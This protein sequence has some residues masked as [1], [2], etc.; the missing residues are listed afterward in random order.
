MPASPF[1]ALLPCLRDLV[2]RQDS[3][4]ADR[5]LLKRFVAERDEAASCRGWELSLIKDRLERGRERLRSRLARRGVLLGTALTS[6]WLLESGAKAALVPYTTARAA[7]L[8]AI[9]QATLADLLPVPVAALSRGGTTTML[10]CRL[11]ILA[12]CLVLALGAAVGLT[13]PVEEPTGKPA[14]ANAA[15]WEPERLPLT[16]HKGAVRAVAFAPDGKSVAT[17]GADKTIRIWEVATGAQKHKMAHAWDER[18]GMTD[19]LDRTAVSVGVAYSPDGK[20]LATH[21]TGKYGWLVFWDA[22]N[23]RGDWSQ[24]RNQ[25]RLRDEGGAVAYSADGKM[26]VAGFGGGITVVIENRTLAK[27]VYSVKG[28]NGRA[29]VAISP[30]SKLLAV[31][32]GG[33]IQL[34]DLPTG[35]VLRNPLGLRASDAVTSMAFLRGGTKVV[36]ADGGKGI[37]V[38]DTTTGNEERAFE[39]SDEVTTLASSADGKRLAT[40]GVGG[41]VVLWD[42]FGKEQRRFF[43]GGAVNAVAFNPDGTR[44]ATAGEGGVEL[45]DLKREARPLPKNVKLSAKE[46]NAL[47]ADLASGD[48][49][50]VYAAS[51][52]LRADPV[53]SVPFLQKRLSPKEA[54]PGRKRLQQLIAELDSDEFTKREAARKELEKLGAAAE[55]A[56]HEALATRPSLELTRR[57]ERLLKKLGDQGKVPLAEMQRDVRAVRVLAQVGTPEAKKLLEALSKNAPGWL[58]MREAKEALRRLGLRGSR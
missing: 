35:R 46:L 30:D 40:A 8:I 48:G 54:G 5:D 55:S 4:T 37:R 1:H 56:L 36:T 38:L 45:W 26:V 49:G 32:N 23:G 7:L 3:Q 58:V 21:S 22:I 20:T 14:S 28:P 9:G 2:S 12:A 25:L 18:G 42:S 53:R 33:S 15:I 10:T 6:A 43:V 34:V 13:R 24:C 27:D 31:G 39:S 41:T 29:T 51:R 57:L 11:S 52:L 19:N 50:K 47:W 44:L 16:G 17:S